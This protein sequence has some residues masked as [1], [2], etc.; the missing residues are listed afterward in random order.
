MSGSPWTD[1]E[2]DLIVEDYFAMLAK[3]VAGREYMKAA[4]RRALMPRLQDRSEASIEF[5][6]Q[7]IS[8]A[9]RDLGEDWIRGYRPA[10]NY[11][12][13]LADAVMRW[14]NRNPDWISRPSASRPAFGTLESLEIPV[15]LPPTLSNGPPPKNLEKMIQTAKKFD[16]AGRDERNRALGRAGEERALAHERATLH[17]AGRG[18]LARR[19]RWVSEEDGDGAGYDISS[20]EPNG[21]SRLIEVKTTNGWERTP[22]FISRNEV[23][24]SQERPSE[25]RLFRLWNFSREPK[26]FEI[27]PPLDAHVSLTATAFRADFRRETGARAQKGV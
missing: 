14:L 23:A 26:A 18:D 22:F 25:W 7:N 17:C 4:H 20:F 6:H 3:D 8:A 11:Q 19:V 16:I 12:G 13:A 1:E 2:N 27:R 10:R 5:K 24:V 21:R 15:G 9:L